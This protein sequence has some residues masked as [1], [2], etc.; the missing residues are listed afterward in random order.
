MNTVT[1][2]SKFQVVIPQPVRDLLKLKA[3][4][5]LQIFA[6][7]ER[8]ELVPMKPMKEMRG[9]LKGMNANF[10]READRL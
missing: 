8:I 9:F 10:E 7:G 4:Q 6:L 2:S 1:L 5:K 3:G